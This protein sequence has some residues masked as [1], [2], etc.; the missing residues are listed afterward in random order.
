MESLH[1]ATSYCTASTAPMA[2]SRQRVPARKVKMATSHK[3]GPIGFRENSPV[4]HVGAFILIGFGVITVVEKLFIAQRA[5]Q[6]RGLTGASC[7]ET[8]QGHVGVSHRLDVMMPVRS[9]L[10][11]IGRGKEG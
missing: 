11:S 9:F 5:G 7:S 10:P 6:A 1:M 4:A 3:P 2:S 8:G